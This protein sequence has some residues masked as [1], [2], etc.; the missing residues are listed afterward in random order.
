MTI[1]KWTTAIVF[2]FLSIPAAFSTQK[3]FVEN[4]A[5]Y[6]Q[7]PEEINEQ[8][9]AKLRQ[10]KA[11][12][13]S[14]QVSQEQRKQAY[15]DLF[16]LM[17]HIQGGNPP[18]PVM[19]YWVQT[20]VSWSCPGGVTPNHRQVLNPGEL[21]HVVKRGKGKIAMILIPD[22]AF[23]GSV[24]DRFMERN[25]DNYTM[26]A[27]TLPGFGKAG[28]PPVFEHRDYAE[29]RLWKN[30][31]KGI[32]NLMKREKLDRPVLLGHQ[33]GA[34]LAMRT[35][36]DHSD[37]I[38]KVVVLNG[39]LYAPMSTASKPAGDWSLSERKVMANFFLPIELFPKPS[40]ECYRDYLQSFA[41]MLCKDPERA[42]SLTAAA[43]QS[44]AHIVWDYYAELLTTDLSSDISKLRTP[45]LVI[46]SVPDDGLPKTPM[47]Q[48]PVK[49]W[50]A[51]KSS[52]IRVVPFEN[53]RALATEDSPEKLDQILL[54]FLR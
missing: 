29:T 4:L 5:H 15:R 12:A 9:A 38:G 19:D 7:L 26:Y 20:A 41:S 21:G 24:F 32:M 1:R 3:D 51:V 49:Q 18:T 47:S 46:P 14:Q 45:L 44:D 8:D 43:A 2:V 33:A 22:A 35:A 37:V 17:M 42:R 54:E 13:E 27:I 48:V 31:E 11:S 50:E 39:L 52:S 23:D 53:T 40:T 16:G 36:L 28:L 10:L 34:Y 6:L 25:L 30:A